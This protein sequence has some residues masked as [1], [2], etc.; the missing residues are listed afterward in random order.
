MSLVSR[1][2]LREYYVLQLGVSSTIIGCISLNI[3]TTICVVTLVFRAAN[4]KYVM[5]AHTA[6]PQAVFAT[7]KCRIRVENI[8]QSPPHI[9][10][11]EFQVM[12]H[13]KSSKPDGKTT[14]T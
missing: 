6:I 3:T 9:K 11:A 10:N 4:T 7:K 14:T 1:H 13:A 8:A 5:N 12:I 2:W